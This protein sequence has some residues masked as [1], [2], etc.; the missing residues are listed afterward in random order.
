MIARRD[1]TVG[2]A[3]A[4]AYLG[5]VAAWVGAERGQARR[6]GAEIIGGAVVSLGLTE[7][8]HGSDLL[9]GELSASPTSEGY[10]ARGE[11]WLINNASPVQLGFVLARNSSGGGP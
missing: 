11:K 9:A 5:A 6:I 10:S 8:E 7:R 3:H 2:I 4:K 1:P